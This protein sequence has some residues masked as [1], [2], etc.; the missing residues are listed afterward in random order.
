MSRLLFVYLFITMPDTKE[1]RAMVQRLCKVGRLYG[2]QIV[3]D[4]AGRSKVEELNDRINAH[5][6]ISPADRQEAVEAYAMYMATFQ[7]AI[8]AA[9]DG[10]GP[11][12]AASEP[13]S[14]KRTWFFSAVQLTYNCKE[15]DWASKDPI[16]L[17]AL[18]RRFVAFV[19]SLFGVLRIKGASATLEESLQT[20]EHVHAH[21]Y[22]HL[23]KEFRGKGDCALEPFKFEGVCPHLVTNKAKGSSF[24]GAQ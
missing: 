13:L 14:R 16:V 17:E 5:G 1:K 20:G 10:A 7:D 22:F 19:Q 9:A 23:E 12:P 2:L 18:F 11:A 8:A 4:S 3:P 15:G 6:A 24:G 21:A